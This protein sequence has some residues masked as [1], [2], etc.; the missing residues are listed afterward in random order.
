[1]QIYLYG[2]DDNFSITIVNFFFPSTGPGDAA[3]T[4]PVP[5]KTVIVL[6]HSSQFRTVC[7]EH[8]D[9]DVFTKSR[10]PG[11][12]PLAPITKTMWTCNVEAIMEYSRIIYDIF[13]S[14]RL[15]RGAQCFSFLPWYDYLHAC[16][17]C[18]AFIMQL[19]LLKILTIDT[20]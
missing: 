7:K 17:L 2:S 18:S 10:A 19:S 1:M 5:H 13:P 4:F 12:I 6:D 9:L 20:A 14:D 15:V 16:T 11:F 8:I 3:M